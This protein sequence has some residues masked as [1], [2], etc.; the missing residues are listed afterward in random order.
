MFV[1][2]VLSF[3]GKR[4]IILLEDFL[5]ITLH[6][7][8]EGTLFVIPVKFDAGVLILFPVS[9]DGVVLLKSGNEVFGM[10]FFHI[11]KAKIIDYK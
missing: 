5:D 7:E 8:T 9:G 1:G 4:G 6:G 2:S 11:F 10:A 3:R